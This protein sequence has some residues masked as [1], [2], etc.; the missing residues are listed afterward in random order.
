MRS[1]SRSL[2]FLTAFFA[3]IATTSAAQAAT[4]YVSN[5][6]VN[7]A[8]GGAQS[9]PLK[10]IQYASTVAKPGDTV[11]VM[12]GTYNEV[13]KINDD[14]VIYTSQN[15]G[16]AHIVSSGYNVSVS[17]F[18]DNNTF[19]GFDVTAADNAHVGISSY[20]NGNKI[21]YNAVHDYKMVGPCDNNGG[22]GIGTSSRA[23]GTQAIG[24]VVTNIGSSFAGNP[25]NKI[26]GI[27]F[28]GPGGVIANNVV[29]GSSA[30]GIHLWHAATDITI[31]HNVVS[32]NGMSGIVYGDGDQPLGTVASNI[33]V[34]DNI[35]TNNG[36]KGIV[37]YG[38]RIGTG[39]EVNN[40]IVYGNG[41]EAIVL[42]KAT[43]SGNITDKNPG[44]ATSLAG[45]IPVPGLPGGSTNIG[46]TDSALPDIPTGAFDPRT[47]SG[48]TGGGGMG[49][50][51]SSPFGNCGTNG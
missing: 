51:G 15:K 42:Q 30:A 17:I 19:S 34:I 6:G 46:L 35:V 48:G 22:A 36:S 44:S 40:N 4:Y 16:A 20:G 33:K 9:S 39:N 21:M 26:H 13:L 49:G 10:T 50:G 45:G 5:S 43:Q 31:A 25:C 1:I 18:G 8:G 37:E 11:I 27:Y 28:A 41:G 32:R 14:G 3:F 24:N 7:A 23:Q 47:G 2:N 38:G 29:T 12:P